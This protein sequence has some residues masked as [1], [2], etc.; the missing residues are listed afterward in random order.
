MP[1]VFN[2]P[3]EKY[4]EVRISAGGYN[5]DNIVATNNVRFLNS[6]KNGLGIAFP[7]GTV[8]VFK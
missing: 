1:K 7:K 8:R 3:I 2:I 5:Q 4:H 6:K